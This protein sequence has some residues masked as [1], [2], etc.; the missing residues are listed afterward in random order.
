MSESVHAREPE[1]LEHEVEGLPWPSSSDVDADVDK[2]DN[3]IMTLSS[4][5]V[6]TASS[7][8]P[9]FWFLIQLTC[10]PLPRWP[11]TPASKSS[12][13]FRTRHTR[14]GHGGL[15]GRMGLP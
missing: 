1:W 13:L 9:F 4:S 5:T 10:M 8:V 14:R 15:S 7:L 3:P 2:D 11:P 6:S 12:V